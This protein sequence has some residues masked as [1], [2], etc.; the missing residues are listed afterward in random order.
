MSALKTTDYGVLTWDYGMTN[1]EARVK[2]GK[3]VKGVRLG[4][5]PF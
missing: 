2:Q 3:Q 5:V 4:H 1:D